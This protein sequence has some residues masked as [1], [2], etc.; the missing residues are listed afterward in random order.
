MALNRSSDGASRKECPNAVPP[1]GG[2]ARV[3][4]MVSDDGVPPVPRPALL[5]WRYAA[6]G[7][8]QC[9]HMIAGRICPEEMVAS[10]AACC[11]LRTQE[12]VLAPSVERR[13]RLLPQLPGAVRHRGDSAAQ[14]KS[15]WRQQPPR[16]NLRLRKFQRHSASS[17][18]ALA[19]AT[20][21]VAPPVQR[22]R[23]WMYIPANGSA[24]PWT[25]HNRNTAATYAS[26]LGLCSSHRLVVAP[27]AAASAGAAAVRGCFELCLQRAAESLQTLLLLDAA[28][29]LQ[30]WCVRLELACATPL[31]SRARAKK[32]ERRRVRVREWGGMRAGAGMLLQSASPCSWAR[33]LHTCSCSAALPMPTQKGPLPSSYPT[34]ALLPPPS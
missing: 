34:T 20:L 10:I 2:F 30:Q 22:G 23:P 14:T 21:P 17:L 9:M 32:R 5:S 7:V 29:N 6:P 8:R 15:A 28:L 33:Q 31:A 13:H 18:Q 19:G 26:S 16:T 4:G 11:A 24:L 12:R 1:D 25:R 27:P 3:G